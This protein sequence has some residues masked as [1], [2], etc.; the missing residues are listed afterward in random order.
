MV[1]I[2]GKL[3][4]H[5]NVIMSCCLLQLKLQFNDSA[6]FTHEYPSEQTMLDQMSPEQMDSP[7]DG[8]HSVVRRGSLSDEEE[9]S[10]RTGKKMLSAPALTTSSGNSSSSSL[11]YSARL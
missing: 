4:V 10:S 8:D 11:L 1:E 2:A 5:C 7:R 3:S 9:E 6:T